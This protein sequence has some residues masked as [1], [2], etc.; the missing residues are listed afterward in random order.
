MANASTPTARPGPSAA[1]R[2][3]KAA[4]SA[5]KVG[6]AGIQAAHSELP[7][8]Q[9]PAWAGYW[10][11]VTAIVLFMFVIY[12]AQKGTLSAWI[13]FLGW[14]SPADIGSATG[15]TSTAANPVVGT[16]VRATPG[17]PGLNLNNPVAGIPGLGT[18]F[19][20]LLPGNSQGSATQTSPVKPIQSPASAISG[21]IS[22]D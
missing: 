13:G 15:Q 12:T 11:F 16:V 19:Q 10:T 1:S 20:S 4:L 6:S 3:G 8:P 7:I 18:A 9:A 22:R 17:Q 5:G 14:S 21:H 2:I